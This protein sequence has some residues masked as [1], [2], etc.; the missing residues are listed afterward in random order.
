MNAATAGAIL[1]W[2]AGLS[3]GVGLMGPNYSLTFVGALLA[4]GGIFY[5]RRFAEP[6]V[7]R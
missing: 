1:M 6:T 4:V 7:H 3:L 2:M 5:V